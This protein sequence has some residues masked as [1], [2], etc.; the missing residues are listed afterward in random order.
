[1]I[2]EILVTMDLIQFCLKRMEEADTYNS[3]YKSMAIQ[4]IKYILTLMS[5]I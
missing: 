4:Q 2:D 3:E 1:M 5:K